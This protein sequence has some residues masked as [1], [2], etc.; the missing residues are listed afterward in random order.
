MS[1]ARSTENDPCPPSERISPF[2]FSV[3][4]TIAVEDS[5]RTRPTASAT[6]HPSPKTMPTA[7]TAAAV[8]PTCPPPRPRSRPRISQSCF[9]CNSRPTRN[10]IITTPN[11]AKCW[12]AITSTWRRARIGLMTIPAIR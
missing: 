5:A 8:K 4:R 1:C 11:S 10:S 6:L 9:G 12:I 2:S 7:M 3:C